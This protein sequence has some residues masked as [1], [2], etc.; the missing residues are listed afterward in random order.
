MWS[1]HPRQRVAGELA[2]NL[3]NGAVILFCIPGIFTFQ[4]PC[5]SLEREADCPVPFHHGGLLNLIYQYLSFC[6]EFT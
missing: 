5:P 1:S 2:G 3:E 6:A 4:G